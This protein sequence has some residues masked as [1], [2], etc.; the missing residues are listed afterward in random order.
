MAQHLR[1][2]L[3]NA[4]AISALLLAAA[5]LLLFAGCSEEAALKQG[6]EGEY[7]NGNNDDCRH[8]MACVNYVCQRLE[9][10]ADCQGICERFVE[11]GA[12]QDDCRASCENTVRQW[13]EEAVDEFTQ[14]LLVDLTC[15]EIRELER[16]SQEC[17]DR[18]ELPTERRDRC[19]DFVAAAESC[20]TPREELSGEHGFLSNTCRMMGRTRADEYWNLSDACVERIEDGVCDLIYDCFNDVFDL[21]PPLN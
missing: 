9:S 16:P 4:L 8:N 10:T 7:C 5:L 13:S 3:G 2:T 17:Y 6:N 12:T 14:C 15:D 19:R 18:L 1:S 21:D 20:G 11:C